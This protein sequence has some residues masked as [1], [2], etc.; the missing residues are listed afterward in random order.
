M[1]STTK[2]NP[3][4]ALASFSL[5]F[6]RVCEREEHNP[7]L[8]YK[9]TYSKYG[10][11]RVPLWGFMCPTTGRRVMVD[12]I[13]ELIFV[14]KDGTRRT[15]ALFSAEALGEMWSWANSSSLHEQDEAM[16]TKARAI[17]FWLQQDEL[18][19]KS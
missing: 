7:S 2:L 12:P 6:F 17:V 9:E 11:S 18:S 19:S 4:S 1:R 5:A 10:R 15:E 13:G 8:T 14:S 3:H 16:L